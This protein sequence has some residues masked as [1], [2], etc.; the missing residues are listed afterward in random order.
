MWYSHDSILSHICHLYDYTRISIPQKIIFIVR[1]ASLLWLY[2]L[3][4]EEHVLD[5]NAGKH[6][7]YAAT[8]F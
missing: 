3:Q 7:S 8:D 2:F 5:T 1:G 6:L 4:M